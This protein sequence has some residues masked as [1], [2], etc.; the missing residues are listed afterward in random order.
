MRPLISRLGLI[1][2]LSLAALGQPDNPRVL[3]TDRSI[4]RSWYRDGSPTGKRFVITV[5][6]APTDVPSSGTITEPQ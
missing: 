2:L 6:G 5:G 3:E 1:S 4:A